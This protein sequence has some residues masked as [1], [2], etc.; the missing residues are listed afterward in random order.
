MGHAYHALGEG[1]KAVRALQDNAEA[2]AANVERDPTANAV[3]AYV[4]TCAWLAFAL[5]DLGEF[6]AAETWADRARA[7]AEARHHPYSEAIAL[8]LAGQVDVLR[9]HLDRAVGPLSR[10]L[11]VCR[12]VQLTVWQAI[13]AA[14]LGQCM[15][16]LD[17]KQ[18]GL[19]LLDEAVRMSD[20]VGI[21]AYLS[22]WVALLGEGLLAA[23]EVSRAGEAAERSL[24]LARSHAERGHEAAAL[25]LLGDVAAAQTPP[26][27]AVATER[28]TA[29]I[30]LAERLGLR[31]LLARTHL[32]LGQLHRRGGQAQ[33]AEAH[34]ATAVVLF[35]DLGMRPWLERSEPELRALGH[36][37]IVARP[38]VNLYEYLKNRFA[39]D[40][41]VQV[42]LDRRNSEP[43]PGALAADTRADERR[44]LAVDQALRLRGLAVVIGRR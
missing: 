8:T 37:V 13:P 18:D 10:A 1:A 6:D 3:T 44:R 23:G 19:A 34:L 27:L 20:Q 12:D 7:E 42:V 38:N 16:A 40:A 17:R 30:S 15:V 28:Y 32:G 39:G 24:A 11:S 29:A 5:A 43:A 4:S 31:P 14:L 35:S 36:L 25:R 21:K 2:L 9:G 26:R 22:R 41:N 33:A